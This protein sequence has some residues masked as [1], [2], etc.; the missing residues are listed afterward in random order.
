M[1]LYCIQQVALN[2]FIALNWL[3]FIESHYLYDKCHFSESLMFWMSS[4]RAFT[5]DI[6]GGN[7]PV[8]IVGTHIDKVKENAVKKRMNPEEVI[9]EKFHNVREILKM[10]EVECIP[11]NNAEPDESDLVALRNR[12]LELGLGVIDEEIPAQWID[13]ERRIQEQKL[14]GTVIMTFSDLKQLDDEM[15]IP[16]KDTARIE[17]FLGHQHNRGHLIH[18]L[19]PNLKDLII[20]EPDVLAKFLNNLM[21]SRDRKNQRGIQH[22]TPIYN[23]NGIINQK[24]VTEIA[25]MMTEYPGIKDNVDN[26]LNMLI[27]LSVIRPYKCQNNDTRYLLPCLLP[28]RPEKDVSTASNATKSFQLVFPNNHLPPP[29]YHI[30]VGGLL[31]EWKLIEKAVDTPEIYNLYACFQ[32]DIETRQIQIYW[33][34]SC[35]YID[36]QNYSKTKELTTEKIFEVL[37]I[38]QKRTVEIFRVYR[39]TNTS[40]DIKVRCPQHKYSY[41]SFSGLKKNKEAMCYHTNSMHAVCFKEVLAKVGYY[42]TLHYTTLHYTTLHYTTHYTTLHTTL[43]YTTLHYTCF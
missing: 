13:L 12:I 31:N 14:K 25:Q 9:N 32:L 36:I 10:S 38:I 18:F 42:T 30:L 22:S 8:I 16:M 43:H 34:N 23:H 2:Q 1:T 21:R 41:V 15:D 29:F 6:N 4:I 24:Y 5:S 3:L 26:L 20:L 11:I 17:A 7:A 27:H 33:K 40:Y 35:V 28:D 19:H 39:H 37:D